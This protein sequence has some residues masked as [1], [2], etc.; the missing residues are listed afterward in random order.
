VKK[1]RFKAFK[2]REIWEILEL[3]NPSLST[4]SGDLDTAYQEYLIL[5][6]F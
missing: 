6:N 2:K 3:E 5:D 1:R 4:Y